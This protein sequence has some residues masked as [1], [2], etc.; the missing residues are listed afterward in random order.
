MFTQSDREASGGI[1]STGV[2]F[3]VS[4]L[5]PP[6]RGHRTLPPPISASPHRGLLDTRFTVSHK[7]LPASTKA[8]VAGVTPG[9]KKQHFRGSWVRELRLF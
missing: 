4:T 2:F 9:K 6:S 5:S 1:Q 3:R 8:F 7:H